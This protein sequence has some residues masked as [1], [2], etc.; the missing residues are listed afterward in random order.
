M[1]AALGAVIFSAF[2]TA[3]ITA[4]ATLIAGTTRATVVGAAPLR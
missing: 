1:P 2:G 4:G 3:G